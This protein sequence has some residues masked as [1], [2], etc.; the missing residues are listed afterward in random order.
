MPWPSRDDISD[1][2][3]RALAERDDAVRA[4]WNRMRIEPEKWSCS[5]YADDRGGFW[6]VAVDGERVLWFNDN[7][8]GFNWSRYT[9]PPTPRS[10][11][12]GSLGP[13]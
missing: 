2:I 5:P 4:E 11:R 13:R 6:A 7:E 12:N 10:L 9:C 3:A 1:W 8:D